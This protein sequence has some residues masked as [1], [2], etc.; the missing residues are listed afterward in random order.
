VNA[1]TP[2]DE[3]SLV[4][5]VHTIAMEMSRSWELDDEISRVVEIYNPKG[6]MVEAQ[7]STYKVVGSIKDAK[8][9]FKYTHS[10]DPITKE[11]T[12]TIF[13][14]DSSMYGKRTIIYDDKGRKKEVKTFRANGF[15]RLQRVFTYD[16]QGRE[17]ESRYVRGDGTL[18]SQI[19]TT[20]KID[21]NG[22]MV[23]TWILKEP[24]LKLG[25]SD[26]LT[27][28]TIFDKDGNE[29]ETTVSEDG[30][31]KT[32]FIT[33]YH[34]R[35]YIGEY[36]YYNKD[37]LLREKATHV[38]KFDLVGNWV[39]HTVTKWV[40]ENGKLTAEKPVIIKRIFTYY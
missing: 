13:N 10:Y 23:S 4:G 32:K 18:L 26:N 1:K 20:Y 12:V 14:S 3:D 11:E 22:N 31:F 40:M 15:L 35:G 5:S 38:Y 29:I 17:I 21:E 27:Y 37:G 16:K 24:G 2:W 28:V 19:K 9:G 8:K 36:L 7:H 33:N 6:R 30:F 39:R 25:V 34:E